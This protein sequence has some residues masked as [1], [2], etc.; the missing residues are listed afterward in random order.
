[1]QMVQMYTGDDGRSH[2]KDVAMPEG[3]QGEVREISV[4]TFKR[5]VLRRGITRTGRWQ[6]APRRQW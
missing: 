4:P 1:M 3:G 5:A 6:T 2:F